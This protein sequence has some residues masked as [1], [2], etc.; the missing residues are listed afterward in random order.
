MWKKVT[1]KNDWGSIV[2]RVDD[3]TLS[4][5][6]HAVQWP[7]GTEEQLDVTLRTVVED[8]DDHGHHYTVE[9]AV[10]YTTIDVHGSKLDLPLHSLG[11]KVW[12]DE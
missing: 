7:D 9:S 1:V 6:R 5:G 12:V 2:V 3:K 8:V 11:C 4:A 10:P